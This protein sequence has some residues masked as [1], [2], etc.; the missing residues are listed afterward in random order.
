MITITDKAA[1]RLKELLA[2]GKQDYVRAFVQGGGCSGFQ[3]G[4]SIETDP[5]PT[6]QIFESNGIKIL[7]DPISANYL[8]GSS[9]DFV[10]NLVGGGFSFQNPNA[11]G[12]CGCGSSF[13]PK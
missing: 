3:Y 11:I 1:P 10:D 5:E 4:L 9:I 6:D 7:V 13:E 8:K 2:P 12:T